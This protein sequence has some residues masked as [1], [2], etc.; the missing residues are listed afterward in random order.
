MQLTF[1]SENAS[2]MKQQVIDFCNVF[3]VA[4]LKIVPSEGIPEAP[5]VGLKNKSRKKPKIEE[6][7]EDVTN[8]VVMEVVE[9]IAEDMEE[10]PQ[11]LTRE[12][13]M[14]VFQT[15]N[16]E[17]GMVVAKKVLAEFGCQRISEIKEE[18]FKKVIDRGLDALAEI[19]NVDTL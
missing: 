3:G 15:L 7:F 16:K 14:T 9:E 17:K 12:N 10:T 2:E 19:L 11:P 13:V 18:D 4:V 6:V 1:E 8:E 5:R